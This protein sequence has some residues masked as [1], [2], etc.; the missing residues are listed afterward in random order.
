VEDLIETSRALG[1]SS[2][3]LAVSQEDV[4]S[5]WA[6]LVAEGIQEVLFLTVSY[7]AASG[8]FESS[9]APLRLCG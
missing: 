5:G 7:D 6:R 3:S 8:S 2:V 1:V 9:G 4:A